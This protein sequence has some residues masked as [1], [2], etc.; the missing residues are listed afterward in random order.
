MTDVK[1]QFKCARAVVTVQHFHRGGRTVISVSKG[2]CCTARRMQCGRQD[3]DTAEE[4][5]REGRTDGRT[6]RQ[7]ETDTGTDRQTDR[8]RQIERV[9]EREK[10]GG[11]RGEGWGWGER[12]RRS[13]KLPSFPIFQVPVEHTS[14]CTQ[15]PSL[16]LLPARACTRSLTIVVLASSYKGRRE[17]SS[18]RP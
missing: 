6:D 3:A 15:T 2:V 18:A 17:A 7:T 11:E 4:R 5:E 1:D 9:G 10:G 8:Q 16:C 13:R 14:A 12:E